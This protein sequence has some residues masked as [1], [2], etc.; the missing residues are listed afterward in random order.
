MGHSQHIKGLAAFVLITV[1][2]VG[3]IL[4][5]TYS[6]ET[7]SAVKIST[8]RILLFFCF[9]GLQYFRLTVLQFT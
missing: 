8:G 9:Y 7:V 6:E 4:Y 1:I 3:L 2:S 5:F